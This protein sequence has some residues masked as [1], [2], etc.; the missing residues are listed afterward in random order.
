MPKKTAK[1]AKTN[2]TLE[3]TNLELKERAWKIAQLAATLATRYTLDLG[4][5]GGDPE[6]LIRN[7][8]PNGESDFYYDGFYLGLLERAEDLL[9][10]AEQGFDNRHVYAY[11][12]LEDQKFYS[13]EKIAKVLKEAGWP[14]MHG[15]NTV[16]AFISRTLKKVKQ[17]NEELKS[18]LDS[19]RLSEEDGVNT[20]E[21]RRRF[22][23]DKEWLENVSRESS[24]GFEY[25]AVAIFKRACGLGRDFS[26]EIKIERSKLS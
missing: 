5:P 6:Q 12:F 3:D 17:Q 13:F 8:I 20:L 9:T 23:S 10:K 1:T 16:E 15:R 2:Q 11:E 7:A 24:R 21:L 4:K 25:H 18:H 14:Y 19:G 22:I 26:D